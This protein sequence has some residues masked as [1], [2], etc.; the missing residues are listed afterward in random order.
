MHVRITLAPQI[1]TFSAEPSVIYKVV[2]LA[3]FHTPNIQTNKK[4]EHL[5]VQISPWRSDWLTSTTLP[6][7]RSTQ[8]GGVHTIPDAQ[9]VTFKKKVT[10]FLPSPLGGGVVHMNCLKINGFWPKPPQKFPVPVGP[11][12]GDP[13]QPPPEGE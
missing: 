7:T 11:F 1:K 4:R 3:L 10:Y 12:L 2:Q 5:N 13:G 9:G 8:R 6:R